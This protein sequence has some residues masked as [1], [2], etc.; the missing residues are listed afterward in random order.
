MPARTGFPARVPC[1]SKCKGLVLKKQVLLLS[2]A[3][4][5]LAASP[6]FADDWTDIT[7]ALNVPINTAA[8]DNGAPGDIHIESTGSVNVA[9][10]GAAVTINSDN[11]FLA[12]A[13]SLVANKGTAD[14]VGILVDLTTTNL[15]ST[16]STDGC[17]S[18]LTDAGNIDLSGAGDTKRGLWLQGP[19]DDTTGGPFTF[20]GDIDLTGSTMTITGDSSVGVLIDSLA[21]LKGNLTLG[22]MN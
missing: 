16:C 17:V 19:A 4:A 14:A 9:I 3:V 10:A 13:G 7:T 6:A 18:G 2:V 5:A 11:S 12:D 8:A 1:G 15:D 20:T 22:T 21:D